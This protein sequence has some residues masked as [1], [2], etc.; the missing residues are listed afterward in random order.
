M[1][2]I[3]FILELAA[4]ISGYVLRSDAVS[5]IRT[6]LDESMS[7]YKNTTQN[8][9][10][11][12]WDDMQRD[13]N[14]CGIDNSTDWQKVLNNTELPLSCCKIPVG[15]IGT[16]SCMN[17]INNVYLNENGG[18]LS[19]FADYISAHAVSLGA[20]G[21][22]IAVLQVSLLY[23]AIFSGIPN[24]ILFIFSSLA[25]YLPVIQRER[26][27]YAMASQASCR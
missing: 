3:I 17:D 27:K 9:T 24:F 5:L 14:C 19:G 25:S 8:P 21:V 15:A 2:F 12:L 26:L 18:C 22:V 11:A 4:G 20:A 23:I 7:S 6:S 13:F 16:F 10:T 1:L